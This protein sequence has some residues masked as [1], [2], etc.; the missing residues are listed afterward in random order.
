MVAAEPD[1]V[2]AGQQG[3]QQVGQGRL[4]GLQ[5]GV[6]QGQ[7][8][9]IPQLAIKTDLEVG[10]DAIAEHV[11]RL[12]DAAGG[13]AGA[14]TVGDPAIPGQAGHGEGQARPQGF[15]AQKS[16]LGLERKSA[17]GCGALSNR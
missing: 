10:V 12:A 6:G 13:E 4:H 1:H 8:A 16:A 2:M 7:I 11:A 15:T 9:G 17:H 5:A 3:L 14:G